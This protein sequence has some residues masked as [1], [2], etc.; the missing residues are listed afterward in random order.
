M[1]NGAYDDWHDEGGRLIRCWDCGAH[2]PAAEVD[3]MY[4]DDDAA[5]AA[6]GMDAHEKWCGFRPENA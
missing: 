4:A 3:A 1:L 6:I 5:L 2:L